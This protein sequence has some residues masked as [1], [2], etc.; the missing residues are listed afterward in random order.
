MVDQYYLVEEEKKW[1]FKEPS[2]L[3]KFVEDKFEE[4]MLASC[5]VVGIEDAKVVLSNIGMKK[6]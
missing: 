5:I 3:T 1:N 4:K 2:I 6:S